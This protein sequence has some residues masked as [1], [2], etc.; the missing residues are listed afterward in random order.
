[1]II[2]GTAAG[3]VTGGFDNFNP[4]IIGTGTFSF[5][6]S[7]VTAAT[8]VD[9]VVFSFGTGPDAVIAVPAPLIGH[10]LLALLAIGGA[11]FGGKIL[12]RTA[13]LRSM[14]FTHDA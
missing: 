11:L 10:G 14:I 4:Y 2:P 8:I 12:D 9:S 5:S 7:G 6:A 13:F 3:G 1:M